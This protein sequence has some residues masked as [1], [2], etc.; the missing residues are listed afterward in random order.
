MAEKM[1]KGADIGHNRKFDADAIREL[2]KA[3]L[4]LEEQRNEINE[5][6]KSLRN[7]F[8]ADTGITIA[9]FN[10]ARRMAMLD[11]DQER[12]DKMECFRQCF[13]ALTEGEQLDWIEG[14]R[15]SK[16]QTADAII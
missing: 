16:P 12:I 11:D 9:D 10:A 15:A 4:P 14:V 5:K 13:N 3:L 1:K 6:M 2:H 7:Q 8:K